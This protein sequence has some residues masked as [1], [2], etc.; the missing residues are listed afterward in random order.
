MELFI[1]QVLLTV[2]LNR[3]EESFWTSSGVFERSLELSGRS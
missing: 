1:E 2:D 3:F